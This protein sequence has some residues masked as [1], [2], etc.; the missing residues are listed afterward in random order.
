MTPFAQRRLRNIS[1][2][3]LAGGLIVLTD[4]LYRISLRDPAFFNGWILFGGMVFLTLLNL[5]KK[6]PVPPLLS[7]AAWLQIHV[8]GGVLCVVLF[9]VH[10]SFRLP[11]GLFETALWAGFVGLFVS[12][13]I[14]LLLTRVLPPKIG[15][16]GERLI[17]ERLPAFRARLADQVQD[18]VIQ[19]VTVSGSSAIADFYAARLASYFRKPRNVLSHLV[20]RDTA[21]RRLRSQVAELKHYQDARGQEI[22]AEIDEHIET[23]NHLDCQYSLQLALRAWLFIHIPLGYSV[24]LLS[25][26]HVF[27]AYALASGAP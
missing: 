18:L 1:L 7:A 14:G 21:L 27:L 4:H 22:L 23:K 10:S 6:V 8:Y 12:G 16:S 3:W 9:L 15:G 11:N 26:A 17:F 20:Q 19:S 24:L 13:V 5:R 25:A 2:A